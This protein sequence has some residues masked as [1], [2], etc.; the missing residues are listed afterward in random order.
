MNVFKLAKNGINALEATNPNDFVFSTDYSTPQIV[1][2]AKVSPTLSTASSETFSNLAH[3]LTYTP[4][5]FGFIKF[6]D[7]RV[8]LIGSKAAGVEFYSTNMR[9]NATNIRFGYINNSGGNYTPTF[10][11]LATEIPLSGT[12]SVTNMV[13]SRI[14][15]S[16]TGI[17]SLTDTNPNNKKYDSQFPTLKYFN[18]ATSTINI[19]SATPA[20]NATATAETTIITHNLGYYPFF[21]ANYEFSVDDPGKYYIMPVMFG[22]AGFWIYNMIY[23]TT[24]QLIFRREFGNSFGGFTY[25]AQTIKV[26]WKI[27]SLDL[28]M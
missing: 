15:V 6:A 19:P 14:I 21:G 7:N 17:N 13:G 28:D 22:D 10:K 11:Y 1:K 27:Y 12:P 23:A 24:T 3:G 5:P 20:A 16:K 9:V 18:Q 25:P 26:Y 8:G 4:F 2:T